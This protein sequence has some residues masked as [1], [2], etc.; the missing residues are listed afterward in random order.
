[1]KKAWLVIAMAL[2]SFAL[3]NKKVNVYLIGD[4]TMAN[5]PIEDN[6]ERGWGMLVSEFFQTN[7]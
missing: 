6:P 1:M 5:K 3:P 4:S 7:I 2:L